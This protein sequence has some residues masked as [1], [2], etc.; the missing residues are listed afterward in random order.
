MLRARRSVA[1]LGLVGVLV[2]LMVTTLALQGCARPQVRRL[3]IATGGTG[4]VYYV[5]GGGLAA[6]VSRYVKGVEATAEVT[7]AS[8]DNCKLIGAGKADLAFVM[9]DTANDAFRGQGKF[10]ETGQVPLRTLATLYSNFTH[11]VV[12]EGSG[13][14]SVADL[15]GKKVSTGAPGSGTEVI[16]LRVLEA[17]G[18]DPDKDIVRDRLG[19]SE[20]AGALKDRK[21]DAFFWSGGLPTA[22][23]LDLAATPGIKISLLPHEDAVKKMVEK[24]GPVY[25]SLVIPR[26]TYPN[27]DADVPVSAVGNLLVASEKMDENLVYEIVKAMFEH[28][29]DL[30]AVHKEAKNLTLQTAVLGSPI[31]YHPGAIRYYKEKQVWKGQ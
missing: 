12:L 22:A 23:V 4:G 25:F 29:A 7:A 31:P 11:I 20:S 21:I 2:V 16:A 17:C 14:R 27:V 24:Y 15:R 3:S 30:I 19:V 28:Q 13:I 26:G 18:L 8:V 6:L 9:A 5:Y 10:K 1:A